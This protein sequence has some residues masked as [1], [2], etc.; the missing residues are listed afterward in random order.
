MCFGSLY[1]KQCVLR[2]DYPLTYSVCFNDNIRIYH[3]CKDKIAKSIP[4][5]AVWHH[6]ACRVMTNG[7][8]E[9]GIFLSCPHTNFLLTTVFIF[10]FIYF[11]LNMLSEYPEYDKMRIC[12]MTLIDV[13]GKIAW[14]R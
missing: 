14:V 4:W 12:M 11:I 8:L 2:F 6:E 13:L 9:G 1:F 5:V 7:E 3:E 10:V